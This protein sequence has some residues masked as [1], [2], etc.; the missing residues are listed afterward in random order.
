MVRDRMP[1]LR[2]CQNNS[3]T[4]GTG[5]L[6]EVHIQMSQNKKLKEVLDEVEEIRGLIQLIVENITI[7]K[8]L[9]NNV[10]S[11]S[12]KGIQK[13]L[14]SRTHI[15]SQ[16]SFRIQRKLRGRYSFFSCFP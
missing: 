13:E 3:I 9:H 1:E 12:N 11:Y 8:D 7:V 2:A 4:F 15:I 5:F 14:E 6:Q 10:L 16:T